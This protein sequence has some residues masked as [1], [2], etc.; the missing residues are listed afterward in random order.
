[1]PES[2]VFEVAE[3]ADPGSEEGDVEDDEQA[4]LEESGFEGLVVET[5]ARSPASG[6]D[7]LKAKSPRPSHSVLGTDNRTRVANPHLTYPFRAIGKLWQGATPTG[8]GSLIG[9]RHVLTAA[10][11][12]A[13]EDGIYGW[14]VV[15]KPGQNGTGTAPLGSYSEAACGGGCGI[16]VGIFSNTLR[17]YAVIGMPDS[18]ALAAIGWFGMKNYPNEC[19]YDSTTA[20]LKGYPGASQECGSLQTPCAGN[21]WSHTNTT[22][23]CAQ[24][25]GS[26]GMLYYRNDATAGQSGSAIYRYVGD[27]PAILAVHKRDNLTGGCSN[28]EYTANPADQ[29]VGALLRPAVYNDICFWMSEIGESS[30]AYHPCAD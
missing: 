17:D 23:R 2:P 21:M 14:E 10:H 1:M 3:L 12:V 29:N 9:P 25:T 8:T 28:C 24:F 4:A 26:Y 7:I 16:Y 22:N 13:D 11:T 18:S 5:Q 30:Y 15:F 20:Y 27:D 19:D 6:A